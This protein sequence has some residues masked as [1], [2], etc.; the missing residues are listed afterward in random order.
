GATHPY[1]VYAANALGASSNAAG[2]PA[3]ALRPLA[4]ALALRGRIEVDPT[5]FADTMFALAKARW[6]AAA[7]ARVADAEVGAPA[8]AEPR[9]LASAARDLYATDRERW[10]GEIADI[11]AWLAAPK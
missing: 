4:R 3:A 8:I 1:I 9:A 11:D 5:L 7:A 10:A 2:D 6:R